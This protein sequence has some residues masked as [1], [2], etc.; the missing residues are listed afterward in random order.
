MEF[1]SFDLIG[2]RLP[3]RFIFLVSLAFVIHIMCAHEYNKYVVDLDWAQVDLDMDFQLGTIC[4]T[5]Y[6]KMFISYSDCDQCA[7]YVICATLSIYNFCIG[8][9]DMARQRAMKTA[10]GYSNMKICIEFNEAR[11]FY[12][13]SI[14]VS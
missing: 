4:A 2:R 12:L 5:S 13:F 1:V 14:D 3:F 9:I 7:T 11:F 10:R 6:Y 8:S